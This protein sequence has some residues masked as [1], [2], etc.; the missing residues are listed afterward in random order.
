MKDTQTAIVLATKEDTKPK[1]N[2]FQAIYDRAKQIVLSP[3]GF[4]DK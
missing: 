2:K 1:S 4:G 3:F